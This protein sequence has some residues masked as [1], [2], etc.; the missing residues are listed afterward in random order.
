MGMIMRLNTVEF[1]R[2]S[3]R[4]QRAY[5]NVRKRVA[6]LGQVQAPLYMMD[7]IRLHMGSP[8]PNIVTGEYLASFRAWTTARGPNVTVLVGTDAPQAARLEYGFYGTD[9]LGRNYSQ[10]PRPHMRPALIA[11]QRWYIEEVG[12]ILREELG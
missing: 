4:R 5:R 11:T 9:S 8:G 3:L 7:Q 12:V 2:W 1:N 6:H 10:A